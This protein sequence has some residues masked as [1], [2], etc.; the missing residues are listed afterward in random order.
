MHLL[1]S[2]PGALNP[3]KWTSKKCR[4]YSS[5]WKNISIG[6]E[7]EYVREWEGNPCPSWTEVTSLQGQEALERRR[8][9][10]GWASQGTHYSIIDEYFNLA[11]GWD[12]SICYM[13]VV[14]SIKSPDSSAYPRA[15]CDFMGVA[16]I[17]SLII[18]SGDS[19]TPAGLCCNVQLRETFHLEVHE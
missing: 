10:P 8:G 5:S 16:I 1:L 15:K 18:W 11:N 12:F 14:T 7:W 2:V 9:S 4:T 6:V 17:N 3:A 13:E 19:L